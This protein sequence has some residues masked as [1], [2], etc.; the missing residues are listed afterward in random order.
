MTAETLVT[1]YVTGIVATLPW[2]VTMA[3]ENR[4]PRGWGVIAALVWL[5]GWFVALSIW[6][7]TPK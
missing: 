5:V 4:D 1:A 6:L 3:V 7:R 2:S